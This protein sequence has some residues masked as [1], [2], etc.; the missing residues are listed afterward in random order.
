M[1]VRWVTFFNSGKDFFYPSSAVC[2]RG[3]PLD[4]L[5]SLISLSEAR[6]RGRLNKNFQRFFILEHRDNNNNKLQYNYIVSSKTLTDE[7]A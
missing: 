2:A 3:I 6:P 5:S 4:H 7:W 1:P